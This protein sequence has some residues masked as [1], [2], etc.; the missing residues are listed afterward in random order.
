MRRDKGFGPALGA[1]A[2]AYLAKALEDQGYAV[3]TALS[4]WNLSRPRDAGLMDALAKGGA[5]ALANVLPENDLEEWANGRRAAHAARI[6]HFDLLA[7]PP[8]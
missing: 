7:L 8:K 6:G 2:T 1:T 5:G 4:P 3:T